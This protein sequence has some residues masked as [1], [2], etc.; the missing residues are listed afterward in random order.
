MSIFDGLIANALGGNGGGGGGGGS[1]P[2]IVH[3][4][5]EGAT[6]TLD[7][8]WNEIKSAVESGLVYILSPYSSSTYYELWIV[9]E[10]SGDDQDDQYG[11]WAVTC[12][13]DGYGQMF[14]TS[15]G[16][17]DYPMASFD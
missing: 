9:G 1:A 10:I 12:F 5:E 8:T 14:S 16:P 15:V 17:D 11:Q 13:K 6:W 4:T 7:K 2:L 3:I